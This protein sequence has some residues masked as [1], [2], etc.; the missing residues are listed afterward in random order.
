MSKIFLVD[1]DDTILDFHGVANKSLVYAFESMGLEWKEEYLAQYKKVNDG[2][3]QA[4]ERREL[5]RADLM[6]KRFHWFLPTI[7]YNN[8]DFDK[9]NETYLSYLSTNPEYFNGA[10]TFLKELAKIGRV[11]IVTNGTKNIQKSRFDIS[12]L[13]SYAEKVFISEEV[14]YDKP[15]KEYTAYVMKNI[16]KFTLENCYW[17]GDS[18]SADI[19]AANEA[20][21]KSIWFNPQGKAVSGEIIPDFDARNFEEIL[22][23]CKK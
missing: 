14:G 9:F 7:G 10:E 3:W 15:A 22:E 21:I 12:N 16:P 19:K 2:L 1:A 13:W 18:I 4:L 17:I 5:T 20:G 23:F 8:L 6:S 11:Y